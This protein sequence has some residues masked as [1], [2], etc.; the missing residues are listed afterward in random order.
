MAIADDYPTLFFEDVTDVAQ[1]LDEHHADSNGIWIKYAKK[2]SGIKSANRAE[3]LDVMLCYGWIDGQSNG[4]D[5]THY[6]QKY[7]PR[8]AKSIWSKVNIA[9]VEQLIKDGKMQPAGQAAIDAAKADGRW[10]QAYDSPSNAVAPDDLI[11]ALDEH[12]KAKE[13]YATLNK[14]NTYAIIWRLQTA[15]K[16]ETRANRLAKIIAMLDN[17]EKFH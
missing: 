12:P 4:I 11:A 5:E 9:K 14:T 7:T 2:T 13:F 8:R 15:K 1:W 6:L 10:A 16:P 17:G 3:V